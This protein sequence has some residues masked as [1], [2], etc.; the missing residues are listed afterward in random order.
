[1]Y[2]SRFGM[3]SAYQNPFHNVFI[4]KN[5]QK[6]IFSIN[7]NAYTQVV[8]GSTDMELVSDILWLMQSHDTYIL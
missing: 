4:S 6:D 2:T 3:S 7:K 5:I 8:T 1:M